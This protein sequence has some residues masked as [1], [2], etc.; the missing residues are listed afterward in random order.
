[1]NESAS[2]AAELE[3]SLLLA[4]T[5]AAREANADR[6]RRL[7][8]DADL[9]RLALTLARRR[10][11]PLLGTRLRSLMG[12]DQLPDEFV[13]QVERSR[14]RARAAAMAVQAHTQ[15]VIAAFATEGIRAMELKG[16]GL[17]ER[18]HGD[19]G[20]R[21]SGD[22]DVLVH[23]RDLFGA[24]ELL[25]ATG[26]DAPRDPVDRHGVP[27]LHFSLPHPTRPVVEVHWRVHWYEDAFAADLLRRATPSRDASLVPD[28]ADDAAALLL[29]YARDGFGGLRILSDL[30]G[31]WE[32]HADADR[33][34]LLDGHVAQYPELART[35]RAAALVAEQVGGLPTGGLVSQALPP[36]RRATLAVRLTSWSQRD[37]SD[38]LAANLELIDGLFTPR[39]KLGGFLRRLLP[40]ER[41]LTHVVK[42]LA[43]WVYAL[44][45]IR[46]HPWDH[47]LLESARTPTRP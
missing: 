18:A 21:S 46:R 15:N 38:Q 31:W 44:W 20:L 37:D 30:T 40:P 34:G 12:P 2:A 26:Y 39:A 5:R 4:Q 25:R 11:L 19:V 8:G 45:R 1:V 43:R 33:S 22:I 35:W 41:P 3:L 6:I 27:L 36:D 42:R 17:A 24:V 7:A 23:R 14:A 32:R 28:G 10:L 9:G 16:P 29:F 13:T 47:D